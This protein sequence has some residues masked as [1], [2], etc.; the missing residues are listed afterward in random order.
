MVAKLAELE[1]GRPSPETAS[2]DNNSPLATIHGA[3]DI[4][5]DPVAVIDAH[6]LWPLVIVAYE[7]G[8][9]DCLDHIVAS[10]GE[11]D[12][13]AAQHGLVRMFSRAAEV[14]RHR[15]GPGGRAHFGDVRHG[16]FPGQRGDAA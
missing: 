2:T 11:P 9:A 10:G 14:D 16:D 12:V 4:P 3:A 13:K 8:W 1:R 15:W 6:G 5:A 7:R